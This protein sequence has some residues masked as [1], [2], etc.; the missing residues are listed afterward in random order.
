[1]LLLFGDFMN[2]VPAGNRKN[3]LMVLLYHHELHK[4]IIQK[5]RGM[6]LFLELFDLLLDHGKRHVRA[7]GAE[8][9]IMGMDG[10]RVHFFGRDMPRLAALEIKA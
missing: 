6:D 7:M 9:V 10:P 2:C 4:S 3:C 1:M 5:M 8:L